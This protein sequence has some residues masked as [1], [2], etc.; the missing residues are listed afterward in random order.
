MPG[1][2]IEPCQRLSYTHPFIVFKVTHHGYTR[3][4]YG[5]AWSAQKQ[6]NVKVNS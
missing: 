2:S 3:M 4:L 5:Q 6:I 1:H